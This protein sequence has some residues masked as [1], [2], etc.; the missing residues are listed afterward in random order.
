MRKTIES[1]EKRRCTETAKWLI[2]STVEFYPFSPILYP[3][4]TP[5][6]VPM[7]TLLYKKNLN[8]LPPVTVPVQR[9]CGCRGRCFRC[10]M[11]SYGDFPPVG[12]ISI[13]YSYIHVQPYAISGQKCLVEMKNYLLLCTVNDTKC[14][15]REALRSGR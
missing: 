1:N 10:S 4:S 9:L 12:A 8:E 15:R 13:V 11:Q 2:N 3:Q 5:C 14:L 6:C 7:N